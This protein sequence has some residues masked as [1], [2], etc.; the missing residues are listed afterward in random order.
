MKVIFMQDYPY[1]ASFRWLYSFCIGYVKECDHGGGQVSKENQILRE[2][3]FTF[4]YL[5]VQQSVCGVS[6]MDTWWL[7]RLVGITTTMPPLIQIP[8]YIEQIARSTPHLLCLWTR[9]ESAYCFPDGPSTSE[10]SKACIAPLARTLCVYISDE[11]Y[12]CV[13]VLS[14]KSRTRRKT[15]VLCRTHATSVGSSGSYF[16]KLSGSWGTWNLKEN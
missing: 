12:T 13:C 2:L 11:L 4:M 10:H 3:Y 6:R 8:Q 16:C 7:K 1:S 15:L 5:A 9:L 14:G